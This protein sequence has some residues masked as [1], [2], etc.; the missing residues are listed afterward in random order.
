MDVNKKIIK[1]YLNIWV[2]DVKNDNDQF[3]ELVN[4]LGNTRDE[5]I[6]VAIQNEILILNATRKRN[7]PSIQDSL[8]DPYF[9]F[10]TDD[11]L[12]YISNKDINIE[13]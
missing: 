9:F 10:C 3:E 2:A 8:L 13:E 12:T 5:D 6:K 7:P 11:N 4:D 1:D